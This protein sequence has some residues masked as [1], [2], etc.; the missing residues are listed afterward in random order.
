VSDKEYPLSLLSFDTFY[1][2]IRDTQFKLPPIFIEYV[3]ALATPL[4]RLNSKVS[5]LLVRNLTPLY[6]SNW[7]K[8]EHVDLALLGPNVMSVLVLCSDGLVDLHSR[9]LGWKI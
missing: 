3:L 1:L 7:V 9:R 2:A 4:F 5:K 6:L 8:V